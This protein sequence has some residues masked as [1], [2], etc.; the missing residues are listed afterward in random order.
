MSGS[1]VQAWARV[2][3]IGYLLKVIHDIAML[4][5]LRADLHR[6]S[7]AIASRADRVGREVES[8]ASRLRIHDDRIA[9]I[10]AGEQSQISRREAA[11]S[12]WQESVLASMS[13][14]LRPLEEHQAIVREQLDTLLQRVSDNLAEWVELRGQVLAL[15]SETAARDRKAAERHDQTSAQVDNLRTTTED[16]AV[17]RHMI[18]SRLDDTAAK[19]QDLRIQVNTQED[20]FAGVLRQHARTLAALRESMLRNDQRA[21]RASHNGAAHAQPAIEPLQ[22][23][24]RDFQPA[25]RL[26]LGGAAPGGRFCF[27]IAAAAGPETDAIADFSELPFAPSSIAEIHAGDVLEACSPKEGRRYLAH[28]S[29]L[30]WTA[31]MLHLTF[32]DLDAPERTYAHV[33]SAFGELTRAI[34][35][36]RGPCRKTFNREALH[37]LLRE[38]GFHDIAEQP[39]KDPGA[40]G[41]RYEIHATRGGVQPV[42]EPD[43]SVISL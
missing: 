40:H 42:P 37:R 33:S 6:E 24:P 8:H 14:R 34:L 3:V 23:L 18:L 4:P 21:P 30:L 15:E 28:W 43:P 19:L 11:L 2:P 7:Q 38:L 9:Q 26:S 12:E 31:G 27:S 10:Q 32:T 29:S 41:F 20:A 16:S 17:H 35:G 25:V 13:E 1:A 5:V 39:A 22:E 36:Q